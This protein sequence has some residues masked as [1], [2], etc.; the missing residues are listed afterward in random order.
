M[1]TIP[2][3]STDRY[4]VHPTCERGNEENSELNG[5]EFQNSL[6]VLGGDWAWIATILGLSGAQ[7]LQF[8]KDCLCKLSDF[9][10]GKTHTPTP[11]SKYNDHKPSKT[12]FETRTFEII[13]RDNQNYDNDGKS[14]SKLKEI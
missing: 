9:E 11:L 6:L 13:Q 1:S 7:G 4:Q 14:K 12:D 8:C 5:G 3:S 10:K 2:N